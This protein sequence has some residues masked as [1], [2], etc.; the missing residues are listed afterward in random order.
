MIF[1]LESWGREYVGFLNKDVPDY[2]GYTPFV[3]SL[4]EHSLVFKYKG[5]VSGYQPSLSAMSDVAQQIDKY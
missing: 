3:D 1:I 5:Y 4:M 2:K